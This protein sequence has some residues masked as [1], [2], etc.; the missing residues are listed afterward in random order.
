MPTRKLAQNVSYDDATYVLCNN[1]K[2]SQMEERLLI[3]DTNVGQGGEDRGIKKDVGS[4]TFLLDK[5]ERYCPF[6][7]S[8]IDVS[9]CLES[10]NDSGFASSI[11]ISARKSKAERDYIYAKK[12]EAIYLLKD[13]VDFIEKFNKDSEYG[14]QISANIRRNG[15]FSILHAALRLSVD[16]A[17]IEKLL[18]FGADPEGQS[19]QGSPLTLAKKLVERARVRVQTLE[20]SGSSLSKLAANEA[21]LAKAEEN[22]RMLQLHH[23]R[24]R[25]G[26]LY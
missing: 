4:F 1:L 25:N 26:V 16:S 18:G 19:K 9:N 8:W 10:N 20:K 2:L 6:D 13:Q 22:L 7:Q 21:L 23:S 14:S 5:V 15:G 11:S 3:I 12:M 24:K 17:L